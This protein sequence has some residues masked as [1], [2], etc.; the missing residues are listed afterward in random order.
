MPSF[1]LP[2]S[3]C[4]SPFFHLFL[5]STLETKPIPSITSNSCAQTKAQLRTRW[6][7]MNISFVV[8]TTP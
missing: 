7:G 8:H 1:E 3:I 6:I 4:T 2:F 5:N